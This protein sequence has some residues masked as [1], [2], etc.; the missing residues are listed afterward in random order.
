[1]IRIAYDAGGEVV[2]GAE[3]CDISSS[4]LMMKWDDENN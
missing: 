3:V 4:I 1:M 2:E